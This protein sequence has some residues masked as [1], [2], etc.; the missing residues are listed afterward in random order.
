MRTVK[1]LAEITG[2]SVRTLHYY[3][4]IGLLKPT[5]KSDAGYR[6]YDDR[7]LEVL[8]Q[9]LYFKEFDIPLKKIKSVIENPALDRKQILQMQRDMLAIKQER[10]THLISSI[11]DI[12][13]GDNDMDFTVFNQIEIEDRF[14]MMLERMPEEILQLAVKDF[15]SVDA[16]KKH[17]MEIASS[18]DMQKRY[19]KVVEC[20]GGKDAF[21]EA[22]NN[23]LS[24]EE[25]EK[26]EKQIESILRELSDKRD[27]A[28][29]AVEIKKLVE[30]Y[31]LVMRQLC[32]LKEESIV[33]QAQ[34]KFYRN[35][36]IFEKTDEKYGTG[37]SEFF[38]LAIEAVYKQ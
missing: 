24:K 33:M 38:A 11:D 28:P 19:A 25:V 30:K 34:A 22:E 20:Y 17:Y 4:E 1:E 13:K 26:Y 18:K 16:W 37:A 36:L 5:T 27:C 3:D 2:I 10:L 29:D 12:L 21:L 31:G 8:Q 14:Q 6:L 7:A 32:Q 35:P 9:I 23:P 15:G